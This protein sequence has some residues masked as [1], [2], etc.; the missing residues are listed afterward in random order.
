MGWVTPALWSPWPRQVRE[1]SNLGNSTRELVGDRDLTVDRFAVPF[2][3]TAW[4][5]PIVLIASQ[6]HRDSIARYYP[7]PPPPTPHPLVLS[8]SGWSVL[9]VCDM[10]NWVMC[11]SGAVNT[12]IFVWR[13]LCFMY[14][15]SLIHSFFI[16]IIQKW[17]PAI[18]NKTISIA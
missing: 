18:K 13:V 12:H 8:L 11:A 14:K 5:G 2:P 15:F 6:A 17:G 9:V 16:F 10:C 1:V 7:H 4:F 3:F